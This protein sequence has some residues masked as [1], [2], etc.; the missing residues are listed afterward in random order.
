[1]ISDVRVAARWIRRAA[2]SKGVIIRNTK[3]LSLQSVPTDAYKQ[4][5]DVYLITA[6]VKAIAAGEA[7]AKEFESKI[8]HMS[9]SEAHNFIDAEITKRTG[10]KAKWHYYSMPD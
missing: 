6:G 10:I 9:L 7:I 2:T 8:E 1:M 3:P 4:V 5:Y